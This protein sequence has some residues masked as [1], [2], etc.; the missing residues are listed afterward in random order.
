MLGELQK[1]Y[2]FTTYGIVRSLMEIQNQLQL[3]H[4]I[5]NEFDKII[6]HFVKCLNSS[7]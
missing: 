2:P 1:D 5:H 3:L 7:W 6:F 4:S